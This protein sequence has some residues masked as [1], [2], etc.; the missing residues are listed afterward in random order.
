MLAVWDIP[1][2]CMSRPN[3][4]ISLHQHWLCCSLLRQ[5]VQWVPARAAPCGAAPL[6]AAMLLWLQDAVIRGDGQVD[7]D[8]ELR[9]LACRRSA[10][11]LSVSL[12]PC[13]G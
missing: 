8:H 13:G 10:P 6:Q 9:R 2:G 12:A 4:R 1:Q 5:S 7:I 3:C 11:S